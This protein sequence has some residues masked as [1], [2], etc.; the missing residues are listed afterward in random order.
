VERDFD[1]EIILSDS[2]FLFYSRELIKC[3][4]WLTQ[5]RKKHIAELEEE[6]NALKQ[7]DKIKLVGFDEDKNIEFKL[8]RAQQSS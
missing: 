6:L 4:G 3:R 1:C 7:A 5:K 8:R 2:K